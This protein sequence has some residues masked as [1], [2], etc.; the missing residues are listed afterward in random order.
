MVKIVIQVPI[1]KELVAQLDQCAVR[2]EISRAAVIRAACTRYLSEIERNDRVQR[3]V[4]GYQR[5]PDESTAQE[6]L[7][8]LMVANLPDE[9]WPEAPQREP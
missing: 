2:Q 5:I 7:T 3:Y 8:W 1:D 6:T 9:E 4:E